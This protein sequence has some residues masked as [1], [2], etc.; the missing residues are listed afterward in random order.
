M[1]RFCSK[2]WR[3]S[4]RTIWCGGSATSPGRVNWHSFLKNWQ[5]RKFTYDETNLHPYVSQNYCTPFQWSFVQFVRSDPSLGPC[6]RQEWIVEN[7][8]GWWRSKYCIGITEHAKAHIM[9]SSSIRIYLWLCNL[10]VI[11]GQ[12]PGPSPLRRLLGGS[13]GWAPEEKESVTLH[14]LIRLFQQWCSQWKYW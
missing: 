4:T 3:N 11:P 9:S 10:I 5:W 7:G 14:D 13:W 6:I 8:H 12:F 2:N 1:D